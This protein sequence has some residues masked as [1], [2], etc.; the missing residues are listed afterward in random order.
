MTIIIEQLSHLTSIRSNQDPLKCGTV[1]KLG[2]TPTVNGTRLCVL[3]SSLKGKECG[4]FQTGERAPLWCTLLVFTRANGQCFMPPIVV[5]QA[6]DY[7]QDL[8]HNI[9]LDCTVHHT[10]YGYIDRDGWIKAMTKFSNRCGASPVNNQ[11]IFFNGHDSHFDGCALT[12]MQK[13]NIHP[14]ILKVSDSINYQPND[15]G[16]NSKL[17]ALYI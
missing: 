11:M 4:N 15:N 14:F 2:L 8:H 1:M 6:K 12:Q 10:P 9:P 13:K 16:P 3:T 7:S 17:K 5:H